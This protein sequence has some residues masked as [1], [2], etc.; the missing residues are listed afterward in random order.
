MNL[1]K[2]QQLLIAALC[3]IFAITRLGICAPPATAPSTLEP[4]QSEAL[5][6]A[7][8]PPFP[9][10][11]THPA[12]EIRGVWISSNE[13]LLPR[14]P[15]L[16][17]LDALKS[18]NFNTILIDTYF[19][20]YIAYPGSA[21]LPQYPGFKGQDII[22]LLVDE[23][24]KRG[25]QAHLWMEYG[26]YAYVTKDAAHDAS[27]GPILDKNPE[28]YIWNLLVLPLSLIV[29]EI[30]EVVRWMPRRRRKRRSEAT[31]EST[32]TRREWLGGAVVSVSPLLAGGIAARALEQ[33][34]DLRVRSLDV[35]IADLPP[36][37]HGLTIAQV[38]DIHIGK[39]TRSGML[40]RIVET[41]N[42]LRADLV[43]FNGDLIDLSLADFPMGV[44][45]INRLDP[46]HGL[47]MIEGNH[48]LIEDPVE[49]ERRA[50]AANLPILLD[51]TKTLKVRGVPIQFLGIRWGKVTD[52]QRRRSNN[53]VIRESVTQVLTQRDPGAFPIL[54]AHHPHAFDPAIDAGVPLTLSGHTHGGQLM[55]NERLGAGPVMFRYWSGLYQKAKSSLVVSN[56]AGN[57]FPLRINAPAE[58]VKITLRPLSS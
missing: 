19:R 4:G 43:V 3:G 25:M 23:A 26:F 44:D 12:T 5:Q 28:L 40:D 15:L 41:T 1:R 6:R 46:R 39:F 27:M 7:P 51:E 45:V 22:G 29:I 48:D 2:A 52:G 37:L 31:E 9:K 53:A 24:H 58:I 14:Q 34:D 13:M 50:K 47:V 16:A 30:G 54:L 57:W 42:P 35:P 20:G 21:Y 8:V 55:L 11:W 10:T 17:K 38:T 18:A 49:F 32:V 36:E 56:G 33:L